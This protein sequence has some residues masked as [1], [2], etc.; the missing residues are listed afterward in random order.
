M[1]CRA[2]GAQTT[3]G[4]TACTSCGVALTTNAMAAPPP[5]AQPSPPS[6]P[7]MTA[8]APW[9][10][11]PQQPPPWRP[12]PQPRR[13]LP[14]L[15][16]MAPP[17]VYG[18]AAAV[19]AAPAALQLTPETKTRAVVVLVGGALM[20]IGPLLPW[21]TASS[22]IASLSVKGLDKG[23]GPI[24]LTAGIITALLAIMVLAGNIKSKVGIATFVLACIAI[25]FCIGNYAT[26]SD[27]VSKAKDLSVDAS[28]GIGLYLTILG[29]L[30]SGIAS[31][32]LQ[33][34]LRAGSR[35]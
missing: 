33:K 8:A 5:L 13:A 19:A 23:A 10:P 9:P 29:C 2:C 27:D 16:S 1:F 6:P 11:Q 14:P 34:G 20:V 28:I 4:D 15:G 31:I 35:P 26:I 7:P 17:P 3:V 24:A 25:V 18:Q 21:E 30:M 32:L 22:S 12:P